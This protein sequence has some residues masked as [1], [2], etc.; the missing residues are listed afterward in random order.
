MNEYELVKG[1]VLV[2]GAGAAG[3]RAAIAA[4]DNGANVTVVSKGPIGRSGI[5]VVGMGGFSAY[6]KTPDDNPETHFR[7]IVESGK[8]LS[9]Q[10]VVEPLVSDGLDRVLDLEKYGVEFHKENSEYW[11]MIIPG[12]TVPRFL[13]LKGGGHKLTVT[14]KKAAERYTN[15]NMLEDIIISR[16]LVKDN[17][18]VGAIGLDIKRGVIKVFQ[19][20]AL[21]LAAGGAGYLWPH[22][23]CPPEST[24]DAYSLV[25]HAGEKVVNM[26]QQLFYPTVAI[27]PEEIRGQEQPYEV[28]LRFD[29]GGKLLDNKGE[30]IYPIGEYRTRDSLTNLITRVIKEGRSTVH[31]G[32]YFDLTKAAREKREEILRR[33]LGKKR[34]AQFH[35]DLWNQK[36][37]VAP[38]AHTTLG[39][40][41]I[42]DKGRTTNIEGFF[43]CGEATGNVHGANRLAGHSYLDTQVFGAR[44]GKYAAEFVNGQDWIPIN[45]EQIESESNAILS[46][47]KP[48]KDGLAPSKL[49]EKVRNLM[50]EYLGLI[51]NKKGLEKAIEEI[52][53]LRTNYL[54][55]VNAPEIKQYNTDWIEA[56]EVKHMLGCA[57]LVARCALLREESR[58]THFRED[59]P[60]MDNEKPIQHTVVQLHDGQMKVSSEPVNMTK[61]KPAKEKV[62]PF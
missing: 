31:G 2:I 18:V 26:E 58:G 33:H 27:Y 4:A 54:P 40:V 51:R 15:I 42:D 6:L 59:F 20:K 39:G 16:L 21:I 37:E 52:V 43:A 5:T 23:D 8:F 19:C 57:E 62:A 44:A 3:L 49:K 32:V 60:Y 45:E 7:E 1:D 29:V 14:L 47:L 46:Y 36:I 25:Y 10:N 61:I 56:I 53:A 24:G 55:R 22:S 11:R 41:R 50:G 48:K 28:S 13:F 35:I 38:A 34:M 17:H 30:I 12:T 9:D